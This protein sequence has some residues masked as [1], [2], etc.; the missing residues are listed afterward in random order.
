MTRS[1]SKLKHSDALKSKDMIV[2]PVAADAAMRQGNPNSADVDELSPLSPDKTT[3]T[4]QVMFD[5]AKAQ[6]VDKNKVAD[7]TKL[8]KDNADGLDIAYTGNAFDSAEQPGMQNELAG[9]SW[10]LW[11]C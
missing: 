8:L 3:G 10:Q 6:D 1:S 5:A 9:V 7:V 11:C 2:N 4:I